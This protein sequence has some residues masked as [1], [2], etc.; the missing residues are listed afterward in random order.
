MS[1]QSVA[2]LFEVGSGRKMGPDGEC[3]IISIE[4]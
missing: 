1:E 2:F 4:K 3:M